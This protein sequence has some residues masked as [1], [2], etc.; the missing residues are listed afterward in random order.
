MT[1]TL[2]NSGQKVCFSLEFIAQ[3]GLNWFL[4]SFSFCV[5]PACVPLTPSQQLIPGA[6][7]AEV[8]EWGPE[9]LETDVQGKIPPADTPGTSYGVSFIFNHK[10]KGALPWKSH[11]ALRDGF[12][13]Q[14]PGRAR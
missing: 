2:L 1:D 14:R 7:A 13:H 6:D 3:N 5:H 9:R 8:G 11:C 12:V 4:L 10:P